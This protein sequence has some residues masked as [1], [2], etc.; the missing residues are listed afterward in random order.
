MW[1]IFTC[2]HSIHPW[3]TTH[4]LKQEKQRKWCCPQH[5][6]CS[7]RVTWTLCT[8]NINKGKVH[9][10]GVRRPEG[11]ALSLLPITERNPEL[12]APERGTLLSKKWTTPATQ[13]VS[14]HQLS[15]FLQWTSFKMTPP[16]FLL[17]VTQHSSPPLDLPRVWL[18]RR[19]P[20]L[21]FPAI[22]E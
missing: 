12:Q 8:V 18:W 16:N 19:C 5:P 21:E 6:V 17:S 9:W 13:P 4:V 20:E 7:S 11:G 3:L 10:S 2:R 1:I 22:P 15:P 14:T